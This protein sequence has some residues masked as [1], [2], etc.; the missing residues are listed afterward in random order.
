MLKDLGEHPAGGPIQVLAGRYGPYVSHGKVNVTL[1]KDVKPEDV[2]VEQAVAW[3][4][5]KAAKGKK[6]AVRCIS[7]CP[8]ARSSRRSGR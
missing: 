5:E 6:A 7:V 2:T 1:P 3:L 4:A 8:R